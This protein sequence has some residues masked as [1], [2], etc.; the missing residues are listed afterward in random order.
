MSVWSPYLEKDIKMLESV[1][2]RVTRSIKG[3]KN[4]DHGLTIPK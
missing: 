1:Q 4:L 3:Y 2:H